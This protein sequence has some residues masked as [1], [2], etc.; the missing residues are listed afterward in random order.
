MANAYANLFMH[1]PELQLLDLAPVKPYLDR[2][3]ESIRGTHNCAS[4]NCDV[5]NYLMVG[6]RFSIAMLL[7]LAI[8]KMA[9]W[10]V[11]LVILILN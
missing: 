7:L 6:D 4:N 2:E 1:D 3:I 5:C 9:V 10:I 8:L 11:I